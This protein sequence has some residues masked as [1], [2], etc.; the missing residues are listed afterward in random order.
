MPEEDIWRVSGRERVRVRES[1]FEEG[2]RPRN[3]EGAIVW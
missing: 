3:R 1:H 2:W